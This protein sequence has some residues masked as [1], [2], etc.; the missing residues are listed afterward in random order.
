MEGMTFLRISP[1]PLVTESCKINQIRRSYIPTPIPLA[2]DGLIKLSDG[3]RRAIPLT[4]AKPSPTPY[5]RRYSHPGPN[6]QIESAF[7]SF[8]PS[9]AFEFLT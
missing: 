3:S 8:V 6:I 5:S 2:W 4:Q 1:E 7:Q 9:P